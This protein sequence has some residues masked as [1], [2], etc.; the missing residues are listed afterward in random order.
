MRGALLCLALWA[1]ACGDDGA[2]PTG[3]AGGA[4][5]AAGDARPA[6]CSSDSHCDDGVYCNGAERCEIAECRCTPGVAV[7]CDDSL[8]CT[9]D[10]CDE[11]THACVVD[12]PD[13]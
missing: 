13:G 3:D 6:C 5:D 7:S 10:R 11:E 4:R 8:S 12:A 2:S 1:A 9:V